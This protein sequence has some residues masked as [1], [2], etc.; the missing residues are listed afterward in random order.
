[1]VALSWFGLAGAIV[2]SLAG[3]TLLKG[4]AERQSFLEQ[5]WDWRQ[6]AYFYTLLRRYSSCTLCVE[7]RYPLRCLLPHLLIRVPH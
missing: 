5:L 2:I 1:M 7:S 3:Q 6:L 4:A